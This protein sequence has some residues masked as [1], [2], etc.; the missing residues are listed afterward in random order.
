M[1]R[2]SDGYLVMSDAVERDL[3]RI[4]PGATYRRVPHPLYAQFDRGR[5]D[6]AAA[7]RRLELADDEE[8]VLFFGYVRR[9]K[10][11][12]TLL[13]AWPAVSA[14][15][16]KARLLVAGEFY[17]DASPYRELAV[18]A[19]G[20]PSVRLL[21]RYLPDDEVEA[22]FKAADVVVLPYRSATQSG[23]T[24]V[25]VALGVPVITT[26]VGGLA[27]TVA[28]GETGMIVPPVDPSALAR[29]I[30]R[31]FA[32]GLGVA[33]RSGV[34]RLRDAHSWSALARSTESLID[35]LAPARGWNSESA[36]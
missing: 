3:R 1:M 19:G 28:E 18:R 9:Y 13:E 12:D 11:L 36:A 4:K 2:N 7:R 10:G 16:P 6:R 32:D 20:A 35:T 23:V 14:S 24:A 22:V 29:A 30:V 26:D 17:E 34:A 15:R 21:E 27:E 25:A 8:V 31:Y 5:Y 33:L